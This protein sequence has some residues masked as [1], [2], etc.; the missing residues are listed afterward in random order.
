MLAHDRQAASRKMTVGQVLSAELRD[1]LL[2]SVMVRMAR[3]RGAL[4]SV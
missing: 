2:S 4:A 3:T 1:L